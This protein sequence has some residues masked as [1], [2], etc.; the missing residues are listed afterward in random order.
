VSDPSITIGYSSLVDHVGKIRLPPRRKN[1]EILIAVQG[2]FTEIQHREDIKLI[3]LE[4]IGAAQSRNQILA[5]ATGEILFFG[6]D[7]M[8][9]SKEGMTSIIDYFTKN[10]NVDL[11]LGQAIDENSHLRKR[12]FKGKR[13]L[14]RFNSAKAATYEI[15]I[16]TKPFREKSIKFNESFGAGTEN[17]LGDEYIFISDACANGLICEFIPVV[18][19]IH[20]S[21]SSGT[22]FGTMKDTKVRSMVFQEIFGRLAPFARLGFVLK[23]PLRFRSFFL[24]MRFVFGRFPK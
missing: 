10:N 21:D 24:I 8:E 22:K 18:V 17:Y 13:R 2:G 1:T 11:I 14:S 4:S 20:P 5:A 3:H 23:D 7:D 19:A 15:A 9:W 6:D 12:Y 16:R